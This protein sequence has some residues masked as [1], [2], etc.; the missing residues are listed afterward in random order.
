MKFIKDVIKQM[1]KGE[2]KKDPNKLV[3]PVHNPEIF[4][5][6]DIIVNN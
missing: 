3:K 6:P 4:G 2:N 5:N 1:N